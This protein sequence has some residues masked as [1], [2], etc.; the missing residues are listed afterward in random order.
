MAWMNFQTP[1]ALMTFTKNFN[2][3]IFVDARG[4][5]FFFSKLSTDSGGLIILKGD[6]QK[7]CVEYAPFQRIPKDVA[8]ISRHTSDAALQ[9]GI[10]WRI[11]FHLFIALLRSCLPKICRGSDQTSC[12]LTECWNSVRKKISGRE[13]SKR[14]DIY[15][16]LFCC[17]FFISFFISRKAWRIFAPCRI[18]PFTRDEGTEAQEDE[19]TS[20]ISFLG[21]NSFLAETTEAWKTQKA[22]RTS[23]IC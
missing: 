7:A 20:F 1:E 17:F 19:R 8:K 15:Y 11:N 13:R 2:G 14:C 21:F 4:T 18:S 23:R 3:H 22:K 5:F 12:Y 16:I 10:I 6:Q 9:E